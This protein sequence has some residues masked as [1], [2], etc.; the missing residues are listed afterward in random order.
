MQNNINHR[1]KVC[2]T[3]YYACNDCNKTEGWK[4]ACCCPEHYQIYTALVFYSR[5]NTTKEQT[6]AYLK[7]LGVT[8]A[9]IKTFDLD[10]QEQLQ[11]IM[12]VEQPKVSRKNK[13]ARG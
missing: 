13:R 9:M 10:T 12:L 1:C 3:G 5:G 4:V 11:K 8:P 2:G 7:S 6:A